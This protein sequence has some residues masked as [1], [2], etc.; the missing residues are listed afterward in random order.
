MTD[1]RQA[2]GFLAALAHDGDGTRRDAILQLPHRKQGGNGLSPR[3]ARTSGDLG[4]V[5]ADCIRRAASGDVYIGI[6][7]LRHIP[8]P[9]PD[10]RP[11]RG[12]KIDVLAVA[13][14]AADLDVEGPNHAKTTDTGLPLP[15]TREEALRVL[16]PFPP[17]TCLVWSGGGW[18]VWW[19]LHRL[20][21]LGIVEGE[22]ITRGWVD[23]LRAHAAELGYH[24]DQT[25]DLARVL[26]LPGTVNFKSS[27][28][29]LVHIV[30]TGPRYNLDELA[31]LM[32]A[33]EP[34]P[35]RPPVVIRPASGGADAME[36]T[37]RWSAETD[38][39]ILLEPAGWICSRSSGA[40]ERHW[41]RPGKSTGTS[42]VSHDDPPVLHIFTS[43]SELPADSTMTKLEVLAHLH[44][45]GDVRAAWHSI[46]PPL[47]VSVSDV[48]RLTAF[49]L[50]GG[51][52]GK[53]GGRL[54]WAAR[55]IAPLGSHDAALR[56]LIRAGVSAGMPLREAVRAATHGIHTPLPQ[57]AACV[58]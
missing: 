40:G 21:H 7:P 49:I 36:V 27:D 13:A 11:R 12:G 34:E 54:V 25:G 6:H 51:P 46:A 9:T 58:E 22:R 15:P 8:P 14:V 3:H 1:I 57:G 26:R 41:T 50:G 42:A 16:A 48:G 44:H 53:A 43:S 23:L 18:Q 33:P 39:S 10:G 45:G 52:A 4:A 5:A 2:R 30:E 20:A 17:A 38:W 56:D 35:E 28:R 47:D 32:P 24:V 29:P 19:L 55:Q 31:Q 37:A